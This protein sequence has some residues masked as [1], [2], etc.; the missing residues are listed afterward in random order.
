MRNKKEAAIGFIFIT[1]LLDV[2]GIGIIAPVMPKLITEL[3]HGTTS[4]ASSYGGWLF[5]SY[6]VMQF[7]ASPILGNLSD[8]YGRRPVLLFSLFGF[9]IDYLFLAYAPSIG[10]LFLGRVIA[11][12]TGA[13]FT[14]ATAYIADISTPEKKAQNFGM[15][16]AAFGLG[17]IIGPVLG[18]LLGGFGSRVPFMVAA[19]LSLANWIYGY[20]ILPESLS[21]EHRRK[22]EWKKANPVGSLRFIQRHPALLP[23]VA[24]YF[25]LY[26]SGNALNTTWSFYGMEKFNWTS[27]DIGISLGVVGIMVSLVQGVLIRKTSKSLGHEKSAYIGILLYMAGML[28]FA[29]ANQGWMMYAFTIVYCLG[30]ISGPSLQAIISNHVQP[31]EQ[32]ALQGALTSVVSI[33]SIIGPPIMTNLFAVC[34]RNKE[35]FY[36]PGAPFYLGAVLMLLSAVVVYR[37]L[38]AE[39][40]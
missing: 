33:S 15:V 34:T 36:L 37:T 7:L 5:F 13:S 10:W 17:F 31:N 29:M 1:L 6:S 38:Y 14:T 16:G 21:Q 19:G 4:Q 27:K 23:L 11:G 35:A 18:G 2:I 26:V 25:L 40:H 12:I 39:K 30:G 20:F 8:Q 32:G 3:I 28:L 22:F 24:S 9:G